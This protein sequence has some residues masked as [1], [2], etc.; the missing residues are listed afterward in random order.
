MIENER[1]SPIALGWMWASRISSLGLAFAIP[2]LLGAWADHQLGSSPWG[3][4]IGMALGFGTGMV[5]IMAIAR[6]G[7]RNL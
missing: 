4:L 6:T 1:R 3:V 2:P 7:T 5:R